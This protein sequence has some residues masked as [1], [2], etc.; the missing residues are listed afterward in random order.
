MVVTRD[1]PPRGCPARVFTP[2]TLSRTGTVALHHRDG[3][4]HME[5]TRRPATQRP[6]M[7]R[8]PSEPDE[9]SPA[10]DTPS[11]TDARAP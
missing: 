7:P 1:P 8:L 10:T 5:P 3:A 9:P 4:W 2:E 11:E 6:W